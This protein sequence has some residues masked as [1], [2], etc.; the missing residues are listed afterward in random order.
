MYADLGHFSRKSVK[1]KHFTIR[2]LL[3]QLS[4]KLPVALHM[5]TD[6]LHM[7]LG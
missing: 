2:V 5:E 7:I 4:F 6:E 1:V 3:K